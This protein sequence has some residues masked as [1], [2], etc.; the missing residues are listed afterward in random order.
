VRAQDADAIVYSPASRASFLRSRIDPSLRAEIEGLDGVEEVGGLGVVLLG[1]RVPGNGPR[2]LANVAL[3]GYELAPD[4]V[5][6]PPADGEAWADEVLSADGVEIGQT[7]LVGPARTPIAVVGWVE[8]TSYNGQAGLWANAETW[9]STL[10]ANRP[11]AVLADGVFQ[12]LVVRGAGSP[13]DVVADLDEALGE[14]AIP[15]TVPDA[16]DE[17]PGVTEQQTTFN[18]ILGVTLVIALVV[19]ALFFALLTVERTALY[20]VLKAVGARSRTIFAGLVVQAV[21]VTSVAAVIAGAAVIVLDL[22]IPPGSIPLHIS[23]GRIVTSV[24]LLLLAAIA[25]C[26]FSLRRVLHI[27]P[28]SALGSS[29]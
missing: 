28:A 21:V 29:Q 12:A 26:A 9:H 7:I 17:I 1:A 14:R 2:D 16:I 6:L 25:G 27:D 15:L 5:P 23:A 13:D 18:Q 10:A 11:D 22:L 8:N 19:I 24:V 20:G 3:W 4:G